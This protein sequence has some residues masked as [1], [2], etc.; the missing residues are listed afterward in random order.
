MSCFFAIFSC[1]HVK[2]Q[3]VNKILD[4]VSS[5]FSTIKGLL[6]PLMDFRLYPPTL[7]LDVLP[8]G[9]QSKLL[10]ID[11]FTGMKQSLARFLNACDYKCPWMS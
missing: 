7:Q 4:F 3:R 1:A 11:I 6:D 8:S 10:L 2:E 9:K 5:T